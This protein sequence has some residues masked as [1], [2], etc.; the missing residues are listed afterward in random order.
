[1]ARFT[2]PSPISVGKPPATKSEAITFSGFLPDA[3][4]NPHMRSFTLNK[5]LDFPWFY[6]F[7]RVKVYRL[8]VMKKI[9]VFT[10]ILALLAGI[11]LIICE[12]NL[13]CKREKIC[14]E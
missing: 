4:V 10:T 8:T 7:M 9:V 11:Y 2:Q 5:R 1:M 6:V 14:M 13:D 12:R 3:G